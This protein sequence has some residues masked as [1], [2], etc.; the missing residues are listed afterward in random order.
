L[1]PIIVITLSG[2]QQRQFQQNDSKRD[3]GKDQRCQSGPA[4]DC[5][6]G[7][8]QPFREKKHARSLQEI[9]CLSSR[10]ERKQTPAT[11]HLVL[12]GG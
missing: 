9:P 2:R 4:S 11:E 1:T 5:H 10:Y 12:P 7:Y 3:P 6:R 8:G